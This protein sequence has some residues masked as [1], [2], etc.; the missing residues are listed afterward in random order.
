MSKTKDNPL[1]FSSMCNFPHI[2]SLTDPSII[3]KLLGR[4]LK[5][6]SR[7]EQNDA[8]TTFTLGSTL[9]TVLVVAG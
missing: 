6:K 3:G 7:I 9:L 5:R 8:S 1:T 4:W 2:L